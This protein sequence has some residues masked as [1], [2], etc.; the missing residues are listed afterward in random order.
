MNLNIILVKQNNGYNFFKIDETNNIIDLKNPLFKSPLERATPFE[1]GVATVFIK[2][3][4][5]LINEEGKIIS[6][7]Y[8]QILPFVNNAAIVYIGSSFSN[9]INKKGEQYFSKHQ[10]GRIA[11]DDKFGFIYYQNGEKKHNA[12][13]TKTL[14]PYFKNDIPTSFAFEKIKNK[15]YALTYRNYV[16]KNGEKLF[17]E[18]KEWINYYY[19]GYFF[20]RNKNGMSEI[21]DENLNVIYESERIELFKNFVNVKID[22]KKYIFNI[23][24]LKTPIFGSPYDDIA[25]FSDQFIKVKQNGINL[26]Y[27]CKNDEF[28]PYQI[29]NVQPHIWG[30]CPLNTIVISINGERTIYSNLTKSLILPKNYVIHD[31]FCAYNTLKSGKATDCYLVKEKETGYYNIINAKGEFLF[32]NSVKHFKNVNFAKNTVMLYNS[33]TGKHKTVKLINDWKF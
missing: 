2:G 32:E 24:D 26:L 29:E 19:K 28:I 7:G 15:L 33:L 12:L 31:W 1:N 30:T 27:D 9:V 11:L 17:K 23:N 22:N 21:I 20:T 16:D 3:K 6:K 5:Y 8:E 18:D 14:Q 4:W 10:R 25:L 13:D